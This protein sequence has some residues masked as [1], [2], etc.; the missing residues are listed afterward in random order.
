MYP[1]ANSLSFDCTGVCVCGDAGPLPVLWCFPPAKHLSFDWVSLSH[2][3]T[4][5]GSYFNTHI[6]K[7]TVCNGSDLFSLK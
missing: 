4:V 6:Y 7:L 5:L 1:P 3:Y 2:L